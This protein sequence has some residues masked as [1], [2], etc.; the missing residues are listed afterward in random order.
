MDTQEGPRR[1]PERAGPTGDRPAPT[2]SSHVRAAGTWPRTA[3]PR[4]AVRCTNSLPTAAAPPPPGNV[5]HRCQD[6]W[7]TGQGHTPQGACDD[8]GSLLNEAGKLRS[9]PGVSV[10]AAKADQPP[11]PGPDA[12]AGGPCPGKAQPASRG[13]ERGKRADGLGKGGASASRARRSHDMGPGVPSTRLALPTP[14]RP[15]RARSSQPVRAPFPDGREGSTD[16]LQ[17]L[18]TGTTGAGKTYLPGSRSYSP[19]F[20][21]IDSSPALKIN[22]VT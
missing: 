9:S 5:C 16:V 11:P 15:S 18:S 10:P 1:S 13:R 4:Q 12:K 14:E 2:R 21:L 22:Q 8:P 19:N 20:S 3:C 17:G 6:G 7:A